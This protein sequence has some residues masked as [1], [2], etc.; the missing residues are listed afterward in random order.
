MP[1]TRAGPADGSGPS[2]SHIASSISAAKKTAGAEK[3]RRAM[4]RIDG[5]VQSSAARASSVCRATR[6]GVEARTARPAMVVLKPPTSS[7][8]SRAIAWSPSTSP[9]AAAATRRL[10]VAGGTV[11]VRRARTAAATSATNASRGAVTPRN[12]SP[13]PCGYIRSTCPHR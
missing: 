10:P 12:V 7:V 5:E 8:V 4:S 9:M 11:E 3:K 6:T 2:D 13:S 1:E